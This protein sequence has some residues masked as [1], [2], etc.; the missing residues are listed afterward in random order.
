LERL[1][2]RFA[3][4]WIFLQVELL[5]KGKTNRRIRDLEVPAGFNVS[6]QTAEKG[7]YRCEHIVRYLD[8]WL[9]PW[10]PEREAAKDWR[11]LM[12]DVAASHLAEE[13]LDVAEARG[14]VTLLHYGCTT[15][16]AQI[17]DTDLHLDLERAYVE[18]EAEAFH[19]QQ[20]IDP[21]DISRSLQEVLDDLTGAWGSVDHSQGL[22]GHKKTGLNNALDGSEDYLVTREAREF[23]MSADMATE[24]Q[25]A[26]AEVDG[27]VDD[28]TIVSFTA[29]RQVV[30]QPENPGI[31]AEEG[32]EF[33]GEL[34][35]GENH[36]DDDDDDDP[37]DGLADLE[38]TDPVSVV[39]FVEPQ[40]ADDPSEVADAVVAAERLTKLR[41]LL[42]QA[43]ES[44]VPAAAWQIDKEVRQ[45][46][47]GL[48]A[49]G[50]P[51]ERHVN[52]VLRRAMDESFRVQA[53]RLK[54]KREE[55]R[56]KKNNLAKVK[57]ALCKGKAAKAKAL[58]A[59]KALQAKLAKYSKKLCPVDCGAAGAQGTKTRIEALERVK[60][61]SPA[62]HCTREA[63]WV[64]VRNAY[65]AYV[66]KH[67]VFKGNAKAV[68][69]NFVKE[70]TKVLKDLGAHYTG[71]SAFKTAP[72]NP[73]A[74][75]L[76][77]KVM[78][79]SLP[80]ATVGTIF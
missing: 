51:E 32:A 58:A 14:Y 7:S 1:R 61:R 12:L 39:E 64:K 56:I 77:F 27:L 23:W 75:S 65:A 74:F 35:D 62:L 10:T 66:P 57:A 55:A 67:L 49:G 5:C 13:V 28:G 50:R 34:S 48:R 45:L 2:L 19:Q 22:R 44:S 52:H 26:I 4:Q 33:E 63:R 15:G 69:V 17:N 73:E 60:L 54:E 38:G 71:Q 37:D 80:K 46:E 30:R 40:A 70:L 21:G 9:D 25:Q 47:R 42:L 53:K 24:R 16:V 8:R 18:L 3:G 31:I 76:F 41:R 68:G 78:E 59:K 29:W 72:G 11:I 20:L 36:W 43:L 79:N 6:L